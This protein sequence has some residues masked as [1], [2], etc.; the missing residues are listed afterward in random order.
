MSDFYLDASAIIKRYSP[1]VGSGWVKAITDPMAGHDITLAE[2]TLAEVAAAFAAKARLP[3]GITIE[4]RDRALSD[5]LRDCD[6]HYDLL[7]ICREL[8][9]LAVSLTQR[10][11]LRGYDAVQLAGALIVNNALLIEELPPLTFVSADED[12]LEAAEAEGLLA[13]NPNRHS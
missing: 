8:I 7:N 10:H 4:E 1:E 12:L 13:E 11:K 3:G 5:F 2:I 9:D 6:E